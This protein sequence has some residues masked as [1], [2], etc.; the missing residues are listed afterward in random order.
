MTKIPPSLGNPIPINLQPG[1]LGVTIIAREGYGMEVTVVSDSSQLFHIIHP[2]DYIVEFNNCNLLHST[3]EQFKQLVVE[4]TDRP[5]RTLSFRLN[6]SRLGN[7]NHNNHNNNLWM[8]TNPMF[9][10]GL[11][12][13]N[14]NISNNPMQIMNHYNNYN[15]NNV[16]MQNTF[17][18]DI[19]AMA[20]YQQFISQMPQQQQQQQ[21][22]HPLPYPQITSNIGMHNHNGN[23]NNINNSGGDTLA[24]ANGMNTTNETPNQNSVV[25]HVPTVPINNVNNTT[26]NTTTNNNNNNNNDNDKVTETNQVEIQNTNLSNV[27]NQS[28]L[29]TTIQNETN[30]KQNKNILPKDTSTSK[31]Q[32]EVQLS[33]Q[34]K[35]LESNITENR[36]SEQSMESSIMTENKVSEQSIT[37]PKHVQPMAQCQP[38]S[39]SSDK[40]STQKIKTSSRKNKNGGMKQ[41]KSSTKQKTNDTSTTLSTT[42]FDSCYKCD[43]CDMHDGYREM[44]MQKC[45][46]CGIYVHEECYGLL[47]EDYKKTKFLKWECWACLCKLINTTVEMY[48]SLLFYII[49]MCPN[50]VFYIYNPRSCGKDYKNKR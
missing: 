2:G 5:M 7:N 1:P 38:H 28:S 29:P 42:I 47:N 24:G 36:V 11:N 44:Y 34:S 35:N 32:E 8:G 9:Y 14:G 49:F 4:S 15:N 23:N 16:P 27:S 30:V 43:I 6:L 3:I 21:Q 50:N 33:K 25:T 20:S 22:Q 18:Q 26:D 31:P 40:E 41:K 45:K 13:S 17:M 48:G 39:P 10:N 37:Q 46:T 19:N 12:T